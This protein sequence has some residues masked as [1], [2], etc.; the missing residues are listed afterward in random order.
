MTPDAPQTADMLAE[1]ITTGLLGDL[2][3][4]LSWNEAFPVAVRIADRLHELG[5][6]VDPDVGVRVRAERP[7]VED[8]QA[9]L[10]QIISDGP[11]IDSLDDEGPWFTPPNP[12][13]VRLRKAIYEAS[14]AAAEYLTSLEGDSA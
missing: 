1:L 9:I 7:T 13:G 4:R 5:F 10:N 2:G 12:A 6:R 11:T 8:L 3:A 14:A